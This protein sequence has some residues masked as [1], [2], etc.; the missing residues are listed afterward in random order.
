M[1]SKG[2][3]R[4]GRAFVE[5][6]VKSSGLTKGL[7]QAGKQLKAF[8][9]NIRTVG[10]QL[11]TISAAA[12]TPIAQA[13]KRFADFDDAMRTVKAVS[14][15]TE[16]EFKALSDKAKALG[17]STSFTAV[18]V[19]AL[20]TELGRAGFTATQIDTMTE[21][22]LNLSRATGTEAATASGIMAATIRQFSLGAEDAT[23][24]ADG[25]TAAANMSFNSVESLGEAM[26]YAGP[27]ALDFGVSLEETLAVL[28][29][30]G[31]LGIQG[32][33][34]GT[35]LRRLLTITGA[36]AEKLKDIFGVTFKDAAGNARPLVDVLEEVNKATEHM[37]TA[38]RSEKF[39][40]AFGLLGITGASAISKS[41]GSTRELLKAI[42]EAGG[43][44]EDTAKQMDSGLGGSFRILQSAVEGV[45]IAI[46]EALAP[47]IQGIASKASGFLSVVTHLIG[48]NKRLILGVTAGIASV[49]GL[50]AA[51]VGTGI[52]IK[53]AGV[54]MVGLSGILAVITSPIG[55]LTAGLVAGAT[56]WVKYS[57]TGRAMMASVADTARTSFQGISDAVAAGD[58]ERAGLIAVTGLHLAVLQGLSALTE[59]FGEAFGA[60]ATQV[61]DGDF[62]G[63]WDT[64]VA[65]LRATWAEFTEGLVAMFTEAADSVVGIWEKSAKSISEKILEITSMMPESVQVAVLGV[66]LSEEQRRR[67]RMN[68]EAR[69][70]GL[71]ESNPSVVDEAKSSA[72][73]QITGQADDLRSRLDEMNRERQRNSRSARSAADAFTSGASDAIDA[74]IAAMQAQLE[75]LTQEAEA[76]RDEAAKKAENAAAG[77]MAAVGGGSSGES[78][79]AGTFSAAAAVAMGQGGGPIDK[80]V[81][82]I[83]EQDKNEDKRTEKLVQAV[84]STALEFA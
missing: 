84:K 34:A 66:N 57:E 20:M 2:D 55:L 33:N 81:K 32:S 31:N 82:A 70:R 73:A 61:L 36:E 8:G 16:E 65:S 6:F 13:T 4:A 15:S 44:A 62:A 37:G 18:E 27:V 78:S 49:A 48:E 79:V 35:T 23:R 80:V 53:V 17:A 58:I 9:E 56:A 1:A 50:G 45:A 67:D 10:Q 46:G 12:L 47:A 24:V 39:N 42:Q 19:A 52:A 74:E 59:T 63:A 69:R 30:L 41:A 75:R 14:Q 72:A 77:G 40:E 38:E 28:G 68:E 64:T 54:A 60:I 51:M 25:L 3:I 5:L 21:A 11:A 22:V 26:S 43:V 71:A 7:R 76:K 29:T 83:E